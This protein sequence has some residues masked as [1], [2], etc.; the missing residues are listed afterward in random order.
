MLP[1]GG[2]VMV[3]TDG[4]PITVF[5]SVLTD[6]GEGWV[7]ATLHEFHEQLS[8]SV[9]EIV[10]VRIDGVR[11][12]TMTPAMSKKFLSVVRALADQGRLCATPAILRGNR[13]NVEVRVH[14]T[15][16]ADLPQAWLLARIFAQRFEP[17]V[18][19]RRGWRSVVFEVQCAVAP[20]GDGGVGEVS[21]PQ[22]R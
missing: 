2:S 1:M 3:K 17:Q 5:E 4:V 20:P 16:A 11:V 18:V 8:R 22:D 19:L 13:L 7:H 14:G 9:R 6:S 12:G 10:E 21:L 15:E